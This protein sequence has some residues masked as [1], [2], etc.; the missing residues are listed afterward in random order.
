MLVP[1]DSVSMAHS[2]AKA[3]GAHSRATPVSI[4]TP[5]IQASQ[6]LGFKISPC[7]NQTLNPNVAEHPKSAVGTLVPY[8]VTV[9]ATTCSWLNP[10]CANGQ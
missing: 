10:P 6:I 9:R 3:L 1:S 8:L 2:G 5:R 4:P 7:L